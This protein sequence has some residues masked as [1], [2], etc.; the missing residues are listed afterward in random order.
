M[1]RSGPAPARREA[2]PHA[3]PRRAARQGPRPLAFPHP[4][5]GQ[6]IRPLRTLAD[7]RSAFCLSSLCCVQ[8]RRRRRDRVVLKEPGG[9][10]SVLCCDDRHFAQDSQRTQRDI[11]EIADRCRDHIENAGHDSPG[12][13]TQCIQ[14]NP[15]RT[16]L[17]NTWRTCYEINPTTATFDG[18]HVHDDLLED[19]SRSAIDAQVSALGGFARRLAA[20]DP[21][22][23]TDDRTARASGPRGRVSGPVSSSSKQCGR[24]E[25]SPQLFADTLATSLAGPGPLRLRAARRAR[26]SCP[27]EATASAAPDAGGARQHQGSARHFRQSRAREPARH[28]S[29]HSRRSPA[30][31][32]RS[33]RPA[34]ARRSRRRGDRSLDLDWRPTSS[35]SR[36][37][38]PLAT[39]GSF[40][41]GR[42]QFEQKFP[43]DEGLHVRRR[44]P[45]GDRDAR[46]QGDAGRIP[47]RRVAGQRR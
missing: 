32:C 8:A 22:R 34:S 17:T 23:L 2:L 36:P 38:S 19:F 31:L 21:M 40:R 11:L 33:W 45:A 46:A 41:L 7:Q 13:C 37:T 35:S 30:G 29:L 47:S 9:P 43:L 27:L 5:P 20:I 12:D 42:E 18:V 3:R 26:A 10:A 39:K 16:S 28:A 15:F 14:P 24:W 44:S 4:I 1:P 25:R 6:W